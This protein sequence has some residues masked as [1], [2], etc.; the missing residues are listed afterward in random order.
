MSQSDPPS[1]PTSSSVTPI[2]IYRNTE[3][4]IDFYRDAF[5]ARELFRL[6][7]PDGK[8]VHA[9]MKVGE[10]LFMLADEH[11]GLN[12]SPES[13][14]QVTVVLS[15]PVDDPDGTM[16]RAVGAGGKCLLP[17]ADQF[18]GERA[19]RLQDPFGYMWILTKRI[20]DVSPEEMQRRMDAM[21]NS[22]QGS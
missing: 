18:Y 7:T 16:D 6:T 14:G 15:L 4:A 22:A 5:G 19:G 3:R 2:L 17:V 10:C 8:I 9:E 11:P 21:M 1:A 20:E 13:T 12:I